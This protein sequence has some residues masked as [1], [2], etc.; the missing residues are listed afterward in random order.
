[1]GDKMQLYNGDCLEVM[2]QLIE[3]GVRVDFILTDIPY[4]VLEGLRLSKYHDEASE[5]VKWDSEIPIKPMFEA[6]EKIMREK[7]TAI[8]FSQGDLTARLR[9]QT[10]HNLPYLYSY[11]WLKNSAGNFLGANKAPINMYEELSVFHKEYDKYSENPLRKYATK[12]KEYIE[13]ITKI[14]IRSSI[15]KAFGKLYA[16]KFFNCDGIQFAMPPKQVYQDLIKE[17]GID[18]MEGFIT[19]DDL[20]E[21]N[22][23]YSKIF[24][25]PQGKKTKQNVLQYAKPSGKEQGYHPTQKPIALLEDLILTYTNEGDTVLDFTMGSGSTGIACLNTNRNYIGIELD[26]EIFNTAKERIEN[27]IKGMNT[28]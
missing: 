12:V 23:N 26:P 10:I 25:L 21:L 24:N 8:L 9:T 3:A 27:H 16:S 7:G 6:M 2:E 14:D 1:M 28:I 20:I 22:K 17:F 19:Y 5:A 18:K 4:G 15:K 13:N 11:I